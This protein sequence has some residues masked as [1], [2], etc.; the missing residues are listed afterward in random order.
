M[1]IKQMES[2]LMQKQNEVNRQIKHILR[3]IKKEEEVRRM[4][5]RQFLEKVAAEKQE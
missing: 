4:R 3:V 5:T 2:Q 1:P